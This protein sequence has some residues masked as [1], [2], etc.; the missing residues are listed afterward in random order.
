MTSSC[1]RYGRP[2]SGCG[3]LWRNDLLLEITPVLTESKRISAVSI[4]LES[5]TI[6]LCS[7]YMPGCAKL[8]LVD[9]RSD[10]TQAL[11]HLTDSSTYDF[12]IIEEILIV[13]KEIS[14]FIENENLSVFLI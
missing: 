6:L 1:L 11:A 13:V 2:Y 12:I 3:I 7:V 10:V 9:T 4:K 5:C 8:C 14:Q